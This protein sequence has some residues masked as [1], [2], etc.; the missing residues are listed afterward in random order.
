MNRC[1]CPRLAGFA[2]VWLALGVFTG[3]GIRQ[4]RLA[5][6]R[7]AIVAEPAAVRP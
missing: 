2:L 7:T 3:D 1:P 4:V 6:R 5:A